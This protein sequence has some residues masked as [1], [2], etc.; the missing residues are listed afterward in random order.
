MIGGFLYGFNPT[1]E[2]GV[3]SNLNYESE[4]SYYLLF[5]EN[6]MLI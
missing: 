6:L 3:L 1:F 4:L 2:V 5:I